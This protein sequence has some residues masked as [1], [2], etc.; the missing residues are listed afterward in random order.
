MA[1]RQRSWG[2][3]R[4]GAGAKSK[5]QHS[6]EGTKLVRIPVAI[7]SQV[8]EAARIIDAGVRLVPAELLQ[9]NVTESSQNENVT[10]SKGKVQ[11]LEKEIQRLRQ[12]CDRLKE[13]NQYLEKSNNEYIR[14]KVDWYECLRERLKL[15]EQVTCLL[16][17]VEQLRCQS[18][19]S[20]DYATLR[21]HYLASLRLGKQ[22]PE[23]KR[24]KK[25]LDGFIAFIQ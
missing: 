19:D 20:V 16:A 13:Q 10:E 9:E 23:Y 3:A 6:E 4:E 1:E 12:E 7:E 24:T 11:Q 21:D 2:G 25:A 14:Q 17:E 22:S 8:L 5:W 18:Q 15:E